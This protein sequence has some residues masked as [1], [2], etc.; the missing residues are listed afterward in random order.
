M[1][2]VRVEVTVGDRAES[3]SVGDITTDCL[4]TGEN[5]EISR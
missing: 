4:E 3:V 1:L 2:S 5:I